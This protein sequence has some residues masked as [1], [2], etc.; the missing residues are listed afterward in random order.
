VGNQSQ[1]QPLEIVVDPGVKSINPAA[2][3]KQFELQVQ[4]QVREANTELHR[5]V[6]KIRELHGN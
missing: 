2:P 4:V 5:A 6:K 1:T 3:E